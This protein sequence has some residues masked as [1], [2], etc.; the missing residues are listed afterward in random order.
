VSD[1]RV[2]LTVYVPDVKKWVARVVQLE[3]GQRI[4]RSWIAVEG[5]SSRDRVRW[6]GSMVTAVHEIERPVDHP[7]AGWALVPRLWNVQ[8][9]MA[10]VKAHLARG[11]RKMVHHPDHN[12]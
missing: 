8:I 12:A 1:E 3:D 11:A 9:P 10:D 2:L 7:D 4:W 6:R 5:G